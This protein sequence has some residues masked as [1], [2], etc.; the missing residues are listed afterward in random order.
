MTTFAITMSTMTTASNTLPASSET[1]PAPASRYTI[2]F[3]TWARIELR[4]R[5]AGLDT[6]LVGASAASRAAASADVSPTAVETP[7]SSAA[8]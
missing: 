6:E 3:A 7:S 5:G 4:D 8:A 1:T 2:G